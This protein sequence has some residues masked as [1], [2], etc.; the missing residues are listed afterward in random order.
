MHAR[1]LLVFTAALG[2]FASADSKG[3]EPNFGKAGLW[4]RTLEQSNVVFDGKKE[5]PPKISDR[6]CG[7]DARL[8][9]VA[10]NHF[11]DFD[12]K[13]CTYQNVIA[14]GDSISWTYSCIDP[15]QRWKGQVRH[16]YDAKTETITQHNSTVVDLMSSN[17][18]GREHWIKI[19]GERLVTAK[20]I[21]SC[22]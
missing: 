3:Q 4:A 17:I 5:L 19:S 8:S 2:L 7:A 9:D 10:L 1:A 11:A 21:G 14:Q 12:D 13:R 22:K 16:S 18:G 6:N 20:R 15:T